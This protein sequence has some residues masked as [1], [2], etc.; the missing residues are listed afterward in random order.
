MMC[1][2]RD[3]LPAECLVSFQLTEEK[4]AL[5]EEERRASEE[6]IQRLLAEEEQLLHEERRRREDDERLARLLSD[7]LVSVSHSSIS[8]SLYC[9]EH[10]KN[11]SNLL[12]WPSI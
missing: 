1:A 11:C 6:Y 2:G 9:H 12:I 4:R 7:Q 5:D 8:W 3:E 10:N